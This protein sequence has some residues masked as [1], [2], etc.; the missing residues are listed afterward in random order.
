MP[1]A[2]LVDHYGYAAVLVGSLLEGE[3]I[4]LL[5]GIAANGGYLS[6]W[7]IVLLAFCGGTI[8]DQVLF[9]LGRRYGMNLLA[10]FPAMARRAEPIHRLIEHHQTKLIVGVRFMYGLRLVGP[11]AIGMSAVAVGR[12]AMLN[13][14]GAALWAPLVV[15]AGYIFGQS[16]GWLVKDLGFYEVAALCLAIATVAAA[17][18]VHR[19]R[20]TRESL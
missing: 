14:L 7:V 9:Q 3:T 16:I 19:R 18:F 17:Y 12:F 2:E 8:G 10:K 4:L 11:F 13:M 6:F 15:G 5:A 1:L 20:R